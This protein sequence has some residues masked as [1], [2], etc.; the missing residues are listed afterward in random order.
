[1]KRLAAPPAWQAIDFI[2]DIHLS[3]AQPRT[4]DA[5]RGFMAT[6]DADA[7]FILGDLFE[8]WVGDDARASSAFE[9]ACAAVLKASSH[10]LHVAFMAG[11][12][13]FLVGSELLDECGMSALPDP[14]ALDAFDRRVLLTHGDALCLGDIDYQRFREQVRSDSWKRQFLAKPLVER[15]TLARAMRDASSEAQRR[16]VVW[17]DVDAQVAVEWMR[18]ADAHEMIHG[19]THRPGTAPLAPG[20]VRHVLSDWDLDATPPRADALR[21]TREGIARRRPA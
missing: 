14:V 15:Q 11:N 8:V 4:F 6:T 1:V 17:A 9:A 21:L 10:R 12:R 5:W 13:D 3:A 16:R 18:E 19:H 20:Y 2:S 7:V